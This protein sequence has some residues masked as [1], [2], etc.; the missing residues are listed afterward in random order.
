MERRSA[1]AKIE[2][3]RGQVADD[4]PEE[5]LMEKPLP[6][7]RICTGIIKSVGVR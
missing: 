7:M 2:V 6:N 4:S 5:L 1:S 3:R